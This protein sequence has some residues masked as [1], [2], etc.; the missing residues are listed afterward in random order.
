[1]TKSTFPSTIETPWN[2][3]VSVA[4]SMPQRLIEKIDTVRGDVPRSVFVCKILGA[5]IKSEE[6]EEEA[7]EN[8]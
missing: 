3:K 5:Q 8:E 1:M 4:I 6:E 7:E 2:R